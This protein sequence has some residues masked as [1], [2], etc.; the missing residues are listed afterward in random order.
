MKAKLGDQITIRP[1]SEL[2][3]ELEIDLH[4]EMTTAG[5][6]FPNKKYR[7]EM[8]T[9]VF[10]VCGVNKEKQYYIVKMRNDLPLWIHESWVD[11]V[12]Q[13]K[14]EFHPP[15]EP[16]LWV[17]IYKDHRADIGYVTAMYRTKES[18]TKAIED[19]EGQFL[20]TVPIDISEVE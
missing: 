2:C 1:W 7:C 14:E 13:S 9:G 8:L 15:G 20:R 3:K 5:I 19:L 11:G 17:N 18:A 10:Q 16:V 12:L 4:G 6:A